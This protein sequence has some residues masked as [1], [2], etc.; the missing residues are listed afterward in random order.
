MAHG[1]S[2]FTSNRLPVYKSWVPRQLRF[3]II[4]FNS[5]EHY[6]WWDSCEIWYATWLFIVVLA[7][8]L[9][10]SHYRKEPF[11]SLKAFCY[12]TTWRVMFVLSGIAVL[13]AS[14]HVLQPVFQFWGIMVCR[15]FYSTKHHACCQRMLWL[16][17]IVRHFDDADN[18]VR[19]VQSFDEQDF[20]NDERRG[21][22]DP[23]SACSN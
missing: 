1:P 4:I 8:T 19:T 11:I 13:Q 17:D 7:L 16:S 20:A 12:S 5:G 22:L 14:A 23:Q 6:D 9:V 18:T 3:W 21:T 10:E 2:P 15:I